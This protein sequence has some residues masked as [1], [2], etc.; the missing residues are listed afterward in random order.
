MLLLAPN[1]ATGSSVE[2][3]SVTQPLPVL[4]RGLSV[5]TPPLS[6]AAARRLRARER[7]AEAVY[8]FATRSAARS[9]NTSAART[10]DHSTTQPLCG[11]A[12]SRPGAL[13]QCRELGEAGGRA[14]PRG[15]QTT[16]CG[17]LRGRPPPSSGGSPRRLCRTPIGSAKIQRVNQGEAP[18]D[19]TRCS[20]RLRR[21]SEWFSTTAPP[22]R[23]PSRLLRTS[24]RT[25][26]SV[27]TTLGERPPLRWAPVAG[28][29]ALSVHAPGQPGRRPRTA[30]APSPTRCST[31]SP[32]GCR[33]ARPR[34]RAAASGP[35]L[36]RRCLGRL[37]CHRGAP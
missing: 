31:S 5:A 20:T 25:C 34:A 6:R 33:S 19:I 7:A 23:W 13:G 11:G 26:A 32:T 10:L 4:V 27:L 12:R 24:S 2:E 30:A 29:G 37:P 28:P 17:R 21:T 15:A 22:P 35:V 9:Q 18:S 8:A 14:I 36:R 16:Q 3:S 1:A